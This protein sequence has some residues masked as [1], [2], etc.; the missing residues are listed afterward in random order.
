MNEQQV[1]IPNSRRVDF[2]SQVNGHGYSISIGL[3]LEPP[4]AEG[5]RVLYVFDGYAYF[6]SATEAVRVNG[7][8]PATVVVGLGYPDSEEYIQST[9]AR[10]APLSDYFTKLPPVWAAIVLGRFYDLSLPADMAGFAELGLTAKNTGGLDDF[11]KIIETE[12]K[13]RVSAIAPIDLSNQAIFGHSLGGLAVLHA[14]FTMPGAFRTFIIASP[15]IHWGDEIVLKNEAK[16]AAAVESG[17]A[18]PR[19]LVTMGADEDVVPKHVLEREAAEGKKPAKRGSQVED[20]RA[21]TARLQAL[22][23][24]NPYEVADYAVF[25]KQGHGISPWPALGRAIS[26]AFLPPG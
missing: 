21:L 15:S 9:L 23:G 1:T 18:R 6:G 13:P 12:I 17:S 7:N 14:L 5:Y 20:A 19:V 2:T 4:P 24:T 3:P 25:P 11:L 10:H 22:R 26:F 8:A 16:F